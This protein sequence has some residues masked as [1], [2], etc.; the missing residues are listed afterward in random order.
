MSIN[1][2]VSRIL[3][4]AIEAVFQENANT[5]WL[6]LGIIGLPPEYREQPLSSDI[7]LNERICM[8]CE[9]I[10]EWVE[11][12]GDEIEEF[13][14]EYDT[15]RIQSET[16]ALLLVLRELANFFPEVLTAKSNS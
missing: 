8:L 16:R 10:E 14:S 11:L 1:Y 7:P 12:H 9:K 5:G 2:P 15:I 6:A 3:K 4:K 13:E